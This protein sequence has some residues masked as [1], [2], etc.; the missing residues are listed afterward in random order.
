[1]LDGRCAIGAMRPGADRGVQG[2]GKR[3]LLRA[4]QLDPV[5]TG[6]LRGIQRGVCLA[7]QR[8]QIAIAA[9]IAGDTH[10]DR[11]ANGYAIDERA[12]RRKTGANRLGHFDRRHRIGIGED[13][14]ELLDAD[15]GDDGIGI[16]ALLQSRSEDAEDAIAKATSV[17]IRLVDITGSKTPDVPGG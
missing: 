14:R 1:M 5:A 8:A 16:D 15:P 6:T 13:R 10:A 11:S 2:L 9:E 4:D 12:R 3:A 7:E 17:M